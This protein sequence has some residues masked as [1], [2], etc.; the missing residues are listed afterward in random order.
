MRKILCVLL[1]FAV[2]TVPA[3][4]ESL[5]VEASIFPLYDW[6]RELAKGS[7]ELKVNL[8]LKNGA[9]LHIVSPVIKQ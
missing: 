2:F 7:E 3:Y 8:L 9:D 6:V 1:C 5:N 4:S